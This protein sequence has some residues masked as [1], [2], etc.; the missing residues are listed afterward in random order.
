MA[1]S[2]GTLGAPTT[3][4]PRQDPNW[5]LTP[6]TAGIELEKAEQSQD[7]AHEQLKAHWDE[8]PAG[9]YH[10]P[11]YQI[12]INKTLIK[13][14]QDKRE[15]ASTTAQADSSTNVRGGRSSTPMQDSCIFCHQARRLSGRK[16]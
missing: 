15:R 12:Y 14:L 4:A 6:F 5:K 8:G 1:E 13:R 2:A 7:D 10:R 16:T 9:A 11:Y 3:K